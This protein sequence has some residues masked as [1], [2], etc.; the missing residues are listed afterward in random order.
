V[1]DVTALTPEQ[2]EK[3]VTVFDQMC[4]QSL[5]PLHEMDKDPVRKKL[6]DRFAR[7]VL[8]LPKSILQP[9]GPLEVLRMKLAQEPSIRGNK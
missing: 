2:L 8:C 5:L 7:E 3:A 9:G 1:L 6:D 4:E